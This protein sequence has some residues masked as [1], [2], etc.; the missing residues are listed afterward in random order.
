[1][2]NNILCGIGNIRSNH[3]FNLIEQIPSEIEVE[4]LKTQG[5]SNVPSLWPA[6]DLYSIFKIDSEELDDLRN[7]ACLQLKDGGYMVRPAIKENLDYCINV[8]R[9]TLLAQ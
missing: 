2:G 8:F 4:I 6:N 1:M 9:H 5:M 3:F 7:R